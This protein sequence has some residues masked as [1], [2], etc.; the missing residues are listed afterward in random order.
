MARKRKSLRMKEKPG[1]GRAVTIRHLMIAAL[2]LTLVIAGYQAV[3]S[4]AG[5]NSLEASASRLNGNLMDLYTTKPSID[6]LVKDN[7]KIVLFWEQENCAGCKV[8]RP[9]IPKAAEEFPDALFVKIHIDKIYEKDIDYGLSILQEYQVLGT[10]TI[11][12]YVN[13]IETG[14]QVGLFP[15]VEGSQLDAL[16]KFLRESLS[17]NPP[18]TGMEASNAGGGD[19]GSKLSIIAD[20]VKG[21]GLGILAA[22]APCSIPMIAA[23][24]SREAG[25]GGSV[26]PRY[27]TM[28]AVITG[29]TLTLGFLLTILYIASFTIPYI[30]IFA[31]VIVFAGSFI[32]SWGFTNLL[33]IEPLVGGKATS[34]I[35]FP[36]LGLQCSLP[37]MILAMTSITTSPLNVL[38][39]GTAFA[40]GYGSPYVLSAYGARRLASRLVRVSSSPLMLRVQGLILLAAGIYLIVE[41]MGLGI[42]NLG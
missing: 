11:I 38:A 7:S 33:G 41:T 35:L 2:I 1:R 34:S 6:E 8:L 28:L 10:P 40:L 9:L 26:G 20:P 15:V 3:S 19:N 32:A 12:V 42:V 14:R 25:R 39:T 37:F 13:G 22:F 16:I 23:F 21:L 36:I 4:I 24:A 5:K 18:G 17:K 30:N 27:L 31:L 29:A